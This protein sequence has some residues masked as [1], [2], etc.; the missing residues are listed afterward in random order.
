MPAAKTGGQPGPLNRPGAAPG[1]DLQLLRWFGAR[2]L[3]HWPKVLLSTAAMVLAA[4][5]ELLPPIITK[6]VFDDVLGPARRLDLLPWLITALVG[7]FLAGAVFSAIRQATIH[8]LGQRMVYG[9]RREAHAQVQRLDLSYFESS[10]TGDVMSRLSNDVDSV[11][12]LVVHGSDSA[13]TDLLRVAGTLAIMFHFAWQLS[14]WALL[15]V[16]LFI[17]GIIYFSRRVRPFYRQVRDELGRINSRLQENI[18]GIRVVKAFAQEESEEELFDAASRAYMQAACRGIWM[19]ATLLP[20]LSFLTSLS[21]AGVL[22]VGARLVG[23]SGESSAATG[24]TAGTIVMFLSY[25]QNFYG[26][27]RGLMGVYNTLNRALASLGR[28]HELFHMA[29]EVRDAA[30]AVDLPLLRGR[31]EFDHVSFRY[32]DGEEVLRE[33]SIVAEPNQTI[34]I[35]GRSGAGKTSIINLIPRFYDPLSGRVL[36][37]GHDL[38][39]VTQESLRRQIGMVLQSTFLF[40]DTVASNIRYGKPE[41]TDEEVRAAALAANAHEFIVGELPEGYGTIVG[42]RGVKLS[43]GQQ[44]RLAIARALLTDPRILILDEATSAVDSEAELKI[45]AA[46]YRLMENRT[47]FVIAH[48]L[49]TVRH[50]DK[51]VVLENGRIVE[52]G[53]HEAL[54]ARDGLYREMYQMQFRLEDLPAGQPENAVSHDGGWEPETVWAASTVGE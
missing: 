47:T 43:G 24:V 27:L 45:Q 53:N 31:V 32:L 14:L 3:P 22:F 18:S 42:E 16:P 10:S 5:F 1:G 49:S 2:L 19:W 38:R 33:V 7:C 20:A 21:V 51:I 50:A 4:G 44:Q 26:R 8:I 37:D 48:R 12:N 28:I 13:I 6:R 52:E 29:P 34:A 54:M 11:E 25:M 17:P 30:D 40:N 35:V 36:V 46:L 39:Q 23:V 41:A 15:P 9:L